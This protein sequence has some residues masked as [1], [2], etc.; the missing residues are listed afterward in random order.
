LTR[1]VLGW[2]ARHPAA[3]AEVPAVNGARLLGLAGGPA[4]AAFSLRT[5]S[6]GGGAGE[7]VWAGV[8]AMTLLAAAGAWLTRARRAPAALWLLLAALLLPVALVNGELRLGAPA[9][10]VL[11]PLAGLALARVSSVVQEGFRAWGPRLIRR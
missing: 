7:V 2:V 10:V 8:L 3:L 4:W 6:L 1:A 11:L 5:M 9:Q